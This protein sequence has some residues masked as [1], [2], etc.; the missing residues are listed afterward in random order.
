V[1]WVIN[2]VPAQVPST[3]QPW[4]YATQSENTAVHCGYTNLIDA[5]L[6]SLMR[7]TSGCLQPTQLSWLPVLSNVAPPSLH[8]KPATDNMLQIIEAHPNWPVYADVFERP[9]PRLAPRRQTW[10]DMTSVDTITQWRED[11]PSASVVNYTIVTDPTIR[12]PGFDLPRHTW[13]PM[14][15]F[16]AGKGPCRANLHKWGLVQSPSCDCGQP[17]TMNRIVDTCLMHINKI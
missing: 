13:S 14:N 9:P 10:S 3:H 4:L 12:Q 1:N 15:R 11:W 17:Q 5:Q 6:H 2:G 7:L 8:R 16:R